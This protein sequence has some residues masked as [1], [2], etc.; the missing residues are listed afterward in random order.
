M[1]IA[2]QQEVKK[3]YFNKATR[4]IDNAR[5]NLKNAKKE[6]NIYRDRKYVRAACEKINPLTH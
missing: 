3:Q 1:S 4:Y 5:E 6:G 2:E